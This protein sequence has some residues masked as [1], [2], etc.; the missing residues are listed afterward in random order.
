[1]DDVR[2]KLRPVLR[3]VT[4]GQ[5]G[6]AGMVP[7]IARP[8]LPFLRELVVVDRPESMAYVVPG[9]LDEWGVTAD[10][11]FDAA[12]ANLEPLAR[13]SLDGPWP[14][15]NPLIRMIDDGN[16]YLTSLLLAPGWLAEVSERIGAPAIAFV[17]DTA[18]VVLRGVPGGGLDALYELVE[19]E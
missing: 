5:V 6:V 2:A 12:R 9:R 13:Q 18:T 8:A 1:W 14:T 11:V 10:D 16:G 3:P 15:D 17:P 19:K 7:P 4:F